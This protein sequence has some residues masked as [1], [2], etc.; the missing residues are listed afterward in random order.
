M[1]KKRESV[2]Q[3]MLNGLKPDDDNGK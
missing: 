3:I 2:Y 1:Q